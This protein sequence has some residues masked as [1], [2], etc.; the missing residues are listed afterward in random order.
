MLSL[1]EKFG[2][3]L[4]AAVLMIGLAGAAPAATLKWAETPAG[5]SG[6][7]TATAT[8][9]TVIQ[10]DAAEADKVRKNPFGTG[11]D[12]TFTSIAKNA[13]AEYS[14][15]SIFQQVSFVWGSPDKFNTLEFFRAGAL[16]ETVTGAAFA[17]FGQNLLM[18]KVRIYGIDSGLGFD[19]VRFSST[20]PAFEFA[21]LEVAEIP[22]APVPAAGLMLLT[23][24]GGFSMLRRRS[25]QRRR[26]SA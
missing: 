5:S 14:F 15:G 19:T 9:G 17:H 20:R 16:V 6:N 18:S 7:P 11:S 26:K 23:A 10:N 13:W 3:L 21:N 1:S 24:L 22:H 8:G 12:Q 4:A 2:G 25:M